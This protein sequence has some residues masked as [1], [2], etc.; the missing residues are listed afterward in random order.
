[1][2]FS[3]KFVKALKPKEGQTKP[4]DIREKS[5]DGFGITVFPS[6]KKS[7]I[8][9][10]QFGARKRR[11]TIGKYP[12]CSLADAKRIHREALT[13][14][15]GGKDPAME[16]H[17]QK[18]DERDASTINALIE[19]YLEKWAIPRKKTWKEDRRILFKDIKPIWGKRK[20]KDI[21]RR[22]VI[23]L[24]DK[25]KERG[26]PIIA[27]R[28][29]ATIRRMFNFAIERDIIE[30][31]PCIRVKA[32]AKENRRDRCLTEAEI[33]ILW[34][35]LEHPHQDKDYQEMIKMS[36]ASKLALKLQLAT[37]QRKGEIVSIEWSDLDLNTRWWT[38]PASKAKNGNLSR[39]YL[40]DLALELLARIKELSGDSKWAFPAPNKKTHITPDS[41]S[42]AINRTIIKDLEYFTPHDLRRTG[43]THMCGMKIQRLVVSKILN[44]ADNSVTAIYD[45]HSY[46]AEKA[47]ALEAW[48]RKISQIIGDTPHANNLHDLIP[49]LFQMKAH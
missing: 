29:L 48:G 45:R 17:D 35:A 25:I 12:R 37:A 44:H 34:L 8:F 4:Y 24:L 5:G 18:I 38:I 30:H 20:A 13:S 10:Y 33:K 42:R 46:D 22:E 11:M 21:K 40:S 31:S 28:T 32:V 7:F 41:L 47:H 26:A 23:D 39:V 14:L 2:T 27:N 43:A 36:E 19:I 9:F 1:M 3:D 49:T 6:G 15:E 16:K